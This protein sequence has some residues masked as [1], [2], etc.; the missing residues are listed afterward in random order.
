MWLTWHHDLEFRKAL[1]QNLA[2][3]AKHWAEL[4]NTPADLHVAIGGGQGFFGATEDE[5]RRLAQLANPDDPAIASVFFK[6]VSTG[7]THADS[8]GL[9]AVASTASDADDRS[10]RAAT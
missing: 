5:V 2:W 8:R 1:R 3:L 4:G 6:A 9:G 10:L 7:S